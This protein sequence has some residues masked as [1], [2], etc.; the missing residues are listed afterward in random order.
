MSLANGWK[1]SSQRE[2]RFC[3]RLLCTCFL[4]YYHSTLSLLCL[5]LCLCLCR[6]LCRC[7]CLPWWS[8]SL[9]L[10]LSIDRETCLPPSGGTW[11]CSWAWGASARLG[12]CPCPTGCLGLP[13][14][15]ASEPGDPPGHSLCGLRP[16]HSCPWSSWSTGEAPSLSSC[17]RATACACSGRS[18]R[19]FSCRR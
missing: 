7:R 13:C 18:P 8:L 1:V 19:G 12:P 5:C 11:I 3:L 14:P 10:S 6:C 4:Y 9:S 16:R 17:R 15:P 2:G